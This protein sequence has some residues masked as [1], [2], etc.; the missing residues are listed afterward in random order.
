MTEFSK[1]GVVK[2]D[3]KF[4]N[5]TTYKF[6]GL[7]K[8]IVYPKSTEQLIDLKKYLKNNKIK[9]MII[10]KGSN[11]VF[12]CNNYDGVLI[13]LEKFDLFKI[14]EDKLTIGSGHSLVKLAYKV[15]RMGYSGLEFAAGI[16]G[17]VGGAVYMNAGAY[18][19]EMSDIVEQATI[20][21]P[22]FEL[23]IFKKEDLQFAYRSSFLQKNKD[24]ICLEVV[25]SLKK[26]N[27]D[28]ILDLIEDRKKR[29]FLSQ[30]IE[31]PSAGSVFRNP[32]N[33]FAGRLIEELNLKGYAVG[34]AL[35]SEK[36]ANFII[37]KGTATGLEVKEL[38]LKIKEQVFEQYQ[39]DLKI[40]QEFIE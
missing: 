14:D 11:V 4:E 39:I 10:G 30:P 28:E 5:H 32:E 17:T 36:H 3:E 24:Y 12:C 38:I 1:Y 29:R 26:A 15:A 20:L 16:P 33:D 13:N 7:I 31:H 27:V 34:D 18:G 22:S 21:T 8:T 37:N 23:V 40:E 2:V 35:V 9:H 6:K 19:F 25:I